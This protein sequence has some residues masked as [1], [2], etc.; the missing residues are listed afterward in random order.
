MLGGFFKPHRDTEK[1]EGMFATL[2][3]LLPSEFE[4]GELIVRH[5]DQ[6]KVF[7]FASSSAY[8]FHYLAFYADCEHEVK[9]V[10]KGS[11]LCLVYNLILCDKEKKFKPP[12]N[13]EEIDRLAKV[14][15]DWMHKCKERFNRDDD[16]IDVPDKL[17]ITLEHEYTQAGISFVV[18]KNRDRT[19]ANSLRLAAQRVAALEA[20]EAKE[21]EKEKG[22]RRK[23]KGKGKGKG[24]EKEKGKEEPCPFDFYLSLL[25]IDESGLAGTPYGSCRIK[26]TDVQQR[27]AGLKTWVGVDE[28]ELDFDFMDIKEDTEVVPPGALQAIKWNKEKVEEATGN[29]GALMERW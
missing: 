27:E 15:Q 11:R 21:K 16:Q 18:L 23:G 6:E 26:M 3:I 24:K 2:V 9:P 25:R 19:F 20:E 14:L 5:M 29:A 13:E 22:K 8:N 12:H 4:G 17:V 28:E 1:T 7:D 10:T